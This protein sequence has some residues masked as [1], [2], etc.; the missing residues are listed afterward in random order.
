MTFAKV[1]TPV[2]VVGF[3]VV[4][5]ETTGSDE[6]S[7]LYFLIE[8]SPTYCSWKKHNILLDVGWKCAND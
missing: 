4:G 7:M 1:G 8:L 3:G 2:V 6:S 5:E